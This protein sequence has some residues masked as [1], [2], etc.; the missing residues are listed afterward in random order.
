M[1]LSLVFHNHQ[2]VGQLPWAFADAWRDA[3][4]PFLAAIQA[5]PHVRVALHFSGPL[6]DWLE[7]HHGE[8][9]AQIAE[10]AARG[11]IEILG[12]GEAEPI[13]AIWPLEDQ[14][15]QLQRLQQK[16]ERLFGVR[17]RGA[18]L[19]ERVWEP[20]L[21]SPLCAAN[22]EYTFVD[23]SV[24]L[25]AGIE[26]NA[27]HAMFRAHSDG[28]TIGVFSINETL[29][30]L[31]PWKTP[32]ETIGYLRQLH[33]ANDQ[34]LAVFADD[35]E[36]FGAWPGTFQYI[37]NEGWLDGFFAALEANRD[38]LETMLPG[39]YAS[40]FAPAKDIALPAGSYSEMQEWSGGNWRFFC[41]AIRK[42]AIC[43]MK[44]CACGALCKMLRCPCASAL[45]IT[46]CARKATTRC[47]T[48]FSA[49]F[50]CV[51]CDR[52]FTRMRH[53]ATHRRWRRA[54]CAR[55]R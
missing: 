21:A 5:H 13:L 41:T 18:W 37:F 16:V 19:A 52:R 35:G 8:A 46:S 3:Y 43:S 1:F 45:T 54:V 55:D 44:P 9:I 17:P 31:I 27:Q 33:A 11:Q 42:R 7:E 34:A 20:H 38:W 26:Q 51:I 29:R 48:V 32:G 25:A 15:A 50:I 22:L 28:T 40:R 39:D 14:I 6:L 4:A 23:S 2:P 53:S 10:L 36:K 49:G 12:G 24:F 47:G 30:R